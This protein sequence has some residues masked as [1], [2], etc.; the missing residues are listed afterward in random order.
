MTEEKGPRGWNEVLENTLANSQEQSLSLATSGQGAQFDLTDSM[1]GLAVLVALMFAVGIYSWKSGLSARMKNPDDPLS[2]K[3]YAYGA[4]V[5]S[6]FFL[7][8]YLWSDLA[9]GDQ[10]IGTN[11]SIFLPFFF[12]LMGSAL[13]R[14]LKQQDDRTQERIQALEAALAELKQ[15]PAE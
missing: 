12:F 15:K 1:T 11:M 6:F 8:L 7:L 10:R 5:M 3:A 2:V 9:T 14:G 13:M 4:A